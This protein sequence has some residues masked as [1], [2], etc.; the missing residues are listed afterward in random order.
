MATSKNAIFG[1]NQTIIVNGIA[2]TQKEYKAWK[3]KKLA[4]MGKKPTKRHKKETEITLLPSEIKEMMKAIKVLKSINAY[5]DNGY[6]QWGTI[7]NLL[8][9]LKEIKPYFPKYRSKTREIE[10][11]ISKVNDIAEKNETDVF[12]YV[13]KLS[14][15]IEDLTTIL[16][17]LM[18]GV[19]SSGV[20]SAFGKHECI[21]GEGRR[22]GLQTLMIR[23]YH[24]TNDL[25]KITNR[26][27]EVVNKGKDPM[28]YDPMH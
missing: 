3:D 24:A 13:Q 12:Q 11:T 18:T 28:S 5:Y 10:Q 21:N 14:W 15:Q 23:A 27:N 16:N 2:M 8:I 7:F 17:D 25:Y 19:S 6:K 20:I 4:D 26:L 22:L 9:G 1:Y